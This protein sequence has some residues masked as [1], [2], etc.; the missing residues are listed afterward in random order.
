MRPQN[1]KSLLSCVDIKD[2]ITLFIRVGACHHVTG[3]IPGTYLK[4]QQPGSLHRV[5]VYYPGKVQY[6]YSILLEMLS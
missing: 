4:V 6:I 3:Q 1:L 2:P 5:L